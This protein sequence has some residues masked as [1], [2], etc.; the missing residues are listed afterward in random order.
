M[1]N[2]LGGSRDFEKKWRSMPSFR[3]SKKT[4]I[5]LETWAKYF[6]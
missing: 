2:M 4:K 3:W 6:Y 1:Y 5:M